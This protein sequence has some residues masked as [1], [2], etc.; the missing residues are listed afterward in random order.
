MCLSC[1]QTNERCEIS[2]SCSPT[3]WVVVVVEEGGVGHGILP[4]VVG[5]D[6]FHFQC[7]KLV[8]L[9]CQFFFFSGI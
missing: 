5:H 4:T 9:I 3:F 1:Q 6:F 2:A 7:L 8:G